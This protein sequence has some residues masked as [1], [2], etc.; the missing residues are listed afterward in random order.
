MHYICIHYISIS[1]L[2]YVSINN[3]TYVCTRRSTSTHTSTTWASRRSRSRYAWKS[4]PKQTFTPS[5]PSP[6]PSY[7]ASR[8]HAHILFHTYEINASPGSTY[9][10]PLYARTLTLTLALCAC[11][12]SNSTKL[13]TSLWSTK[14][15]SALAS[16]NMPCIFFPTKS[17]RGNGYRARVSVLV[18][19]SRIGSYRNSCYI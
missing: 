1:L 6:P 18:C 12:R 16:W 15:R 8:I 2:R 3:A 13:C 14:T 4:H 9:I 5:S 10:T 7:A 17:C 19:A 11:T